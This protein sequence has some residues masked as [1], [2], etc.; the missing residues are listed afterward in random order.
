MKYLM[1]F[2]TVLLYLS[3]SGQPFDSLNRRTEIEECT[4]HT[5]SIYEFQRVVDSMQMSI[6]ELCDYPV[7]FPVKE[8]IRISSGFG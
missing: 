7:I 4:K 1:I 3:A 6:E 8:P 5:Y 2:L